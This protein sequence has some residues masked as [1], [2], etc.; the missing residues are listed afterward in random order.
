M[1][2]ECVNYIS[3]GDGESAESGKAQLE[4]ELAKSAN[5]TER[6]EQVCYK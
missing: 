2:V 4:K 3:Q 5:L 1:Y 6:G